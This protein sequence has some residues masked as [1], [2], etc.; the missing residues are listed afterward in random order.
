MRGTFKYYEDISRLILFS[1]HP[2]ALYV[3]TQD[4]KV[5][6]KVFENTQSGAAVANETVIH[7]GGSFRPLV[8]VFLSLIVVYS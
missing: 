2:L 3:F 7:P 4:Q 5:K 8:V 6:T 1:D